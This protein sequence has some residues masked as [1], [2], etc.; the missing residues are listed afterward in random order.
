MDVHD[1]ETRRYNMSQI[2]G[3]DTKPEVIVRKF[4]SENG[5][6]FSINDKR[7]P[8][9]PDIVLEDYKIVIFI[10]GCF[11]HHHTG[12]RYA[13]VPKTRTEWW[14]EKI[15]KT[16]DK[17]QKNIEILTANG[18]KTITVWECA[19]KGKA[20]AESSLKELMDIIRG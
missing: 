12:C 20:N 10:N 7:L 9:K 17:D 8:G 18:W 2:K 3:K 15:S 6:D 4:L 16:K 11:W 13:V 5:F 14:M 19:L 1:K